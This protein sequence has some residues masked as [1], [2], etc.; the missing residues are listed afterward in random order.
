M[1]GN[2]GV[3]QAEGEE[4]NWRSGERIQGVGGEKSSEG[5]PLKW[6]GCFSHFCKAK[7]PVRSWSCKYLDRNTCFREAKAQRM[8]CY[9]SISFPYGYRVAHLLVF[10]VFTQT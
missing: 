2:D 6:I 4:L 7:D 1:F 8:P 10:W 5:T 3:Y 9:H